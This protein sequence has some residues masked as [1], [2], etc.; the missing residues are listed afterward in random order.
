VI[1]GEVSLALVF[2]DVSANLVDFRVQVVD[3]RE[4]ERLD[5]HWFH[6]GAEFLRAVMRQEQ[7]LDVDGERLRET[8]D[9]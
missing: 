2:G 7:V 4:D 6:W 1:A 8:F 3:R 5:G 9:L